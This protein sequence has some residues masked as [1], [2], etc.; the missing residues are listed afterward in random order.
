MVVRITFKFLCVRWY[1]KIPETL[2]YVA[3]YSQ[4]ISHKS[5]VG[6]TKDFLL[7]FLKAKFL[8]L[9]KYMLDSLYRI[10]VWQVS[11]ELSCSNTCQ[12]QTWYA[13]ANMYFG[14]TEKLGIWWNERNWLNS[15]LDPW[16]V[17]WQDVILQDWHMW[18]LKKLIWKLL[19]H[20]LFTL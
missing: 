12:I 2:V 11:P 1:W 15:P 19:L 18:F 9:Q 4:S 20:S 17:N 7:L 10:Q 5:G 14:Y 13:K 16:T 8:F 6:V 3:H